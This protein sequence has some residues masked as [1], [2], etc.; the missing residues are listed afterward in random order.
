MLT[1]AGSEY[2]TEK[3]K[4]EAMHNLL[5]RQFYKNM[6]KERKTTAAKKNL[7]TD[8]AKLLKKNGIPK[9]LALIAGKKVADAVAAKQ[10]ATEKAAAVVASRKRVA[11]TIK[12]MA[13]F[14]I[15]KAL[16]ARARA[17]KLDKEA[18][19]AKPRLKKS[20]P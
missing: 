7:S 2:L 11:E 10:K 8:V 18:K 20:P 19:V 6:K 1:I 14:I 4:K 13:A 15:K 3:K 12:K 5:Y 9:T 17:K 16:L